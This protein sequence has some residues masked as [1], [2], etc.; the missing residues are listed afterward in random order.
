LRSLP[1]VPEGLP[2]QNADNASGSASLS[3]R[4]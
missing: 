3:A 2:K 1:M 4:F